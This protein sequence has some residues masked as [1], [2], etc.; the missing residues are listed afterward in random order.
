MHLKSLLAAAVAVP[1]IPAAAETV[2]GVYIFSRHGDRTAKILGND[3]LTDLGYEEV[4]TSGTYFRD[5]YIANGS[6][7][8]I[9]GISPDVVNYQQIAASAPFDNVLTPSA[10]GFL[11]GLYPPVGPT[12]GSQVLRNG[13]TVESPMGGFQLIPVQVISSA[14]GSESQIWLQGSTGCA[15]AEESSNE[16]FTTSD[17]F[18]LLNSTADFYQSLSPVINA[19]FAESAISYFNA[20]AS[21]SHCSKVSHPY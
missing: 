12:L 1:L 5:Q 13:T 14:S 16:Y 21:K 17:Y 3:Y 10:Q 9:Y 20:Y 15:L 19:T 11:Q 2:L 8:Q 18:N 6:T 7:S 4:F